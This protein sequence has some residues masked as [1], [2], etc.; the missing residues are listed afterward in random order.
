MYID[1]VSLVRKALLES[2]VDESMLG[3]FDGHSTISL[4]FENYPSLLIS[5][6]DDN[7]W[8]W[9][10]LCE[11]SDSILQHKASLL[12]EKVM[13]GCLFSMTGQLQLSVNDGFIELKGM[14]HPGYLDDSSK[15]AEAMDEFFVQQEEYLGVIR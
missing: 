13:G 10:K 15:L 7:I 14:V 11:A 6:I 1:I 4:D 8:I 9:S 12:L 2:G 3:D 5:M